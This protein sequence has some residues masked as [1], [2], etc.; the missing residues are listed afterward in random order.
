MVDGG[1]ENG[2]VGSGTGETEETWWEK[3]GQGH[4]GRGVEQA[5]II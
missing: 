5:G 2:R 4:E 1:E 3:E